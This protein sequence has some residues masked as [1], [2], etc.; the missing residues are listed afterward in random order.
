MQPSGCSYQTWGSLWP[1]SYLLAPGLGQPR[2]WLWL[3]GLGLGPLRCLPLTSAHTC[4]RAHKGRSL[5]GGSVLALDSSEQKDSANDKGFVLFFFRSLT[6][7]SWFSPERTS[8]NHFPVPV[9]FRL[10]IALVT[11]LFSVFWP[12]LSL[13]QRF[14]VDTFGGTKGNLNRLG[15]HFMLGTVPGDKHSVSRRC[16]FRKHLEWRL[17]SFIPQ[18]SVGTLCAWRGG[19]R[20]NAVTPVG[21]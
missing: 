6:E 9:G 2:V 3:P 11:E 15:D 17:A 21:A 14:S 7:L 19:C 16:Q 18:V 20:T 4:T 1:G 10:S 12:P 13:L 8:L 5:R